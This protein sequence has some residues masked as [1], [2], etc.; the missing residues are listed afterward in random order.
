[1]ARE[2]HVM[3]SLSRLAVTRIVVAHRPETI[4][5]ADRVIELQA[6]RVLFDGPSRTWRARH[7]QAG[8]RALV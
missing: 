4:G 3:A 5:A 7:R 2:R 1:V 8:D 6:G